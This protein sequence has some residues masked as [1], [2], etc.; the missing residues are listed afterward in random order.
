[1]LICLFLTYVTGKWWRMVRKKGA[2]YVFKDMARNAVY[3]GF[4]IP[5]G[6][7]LLLIIL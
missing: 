4:F 2:G 6:I 1:M 7:I 5:K 3:S